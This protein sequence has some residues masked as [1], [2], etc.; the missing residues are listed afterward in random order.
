M[1][2]NGIVGRK[3]AFV[4]ALAA[5]QNV[6]QAAVTAGVGRRTAARYHQDAAVR[7]ALQAAQADALAQTTRKAVATMTAAL[8]VLAGIMANER[9]SPSARVSACRTVLE[10]AVKFSETLDLAVRVAE[11]EER[12]R[13]DT[14]EKPD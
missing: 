2:R 1:A 5:G 13:D 3:L 4:E 8:D 9:A 7:A 6:T 12:M 11:L 14:T 10:M